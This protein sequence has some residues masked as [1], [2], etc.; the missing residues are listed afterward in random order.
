MLIFPTFGLVEISLTR[1]AATSHQVQ[2][3]GYR[4]HEVQRRIHGSGSRC[5]TVSNLALSASKSTPLKNSSQRLRIRINGHQVSLPL[6]CLKNI[7]L[8]IQHK[9]ICLL[10]NLRQTPPTV[11]ISGI[12]LVTVSFLRIFPMSLA[13]C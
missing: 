10:P 6:E 11:E 13:E 9:P 7:S 5:I 4:R 2:D 12:P 3:A 1:D 8:L